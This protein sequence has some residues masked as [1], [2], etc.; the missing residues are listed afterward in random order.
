MP[1]IASDVVRTAPAT[2]AVMSGDSSKSDAD[3]PTVNV[4]A[5]WPAGTTTCVGACNRELL[6]CRDTMPPSAGAGW[7]SSREQT[8]APGLSGSGAHESE[9][10]MLVA[11]AW[12]LIGTESDVPPKEA[13]I[14]AV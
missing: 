12:R 3:T 8:K 9:L 11:G 13:V 1:T 7:L 5:R 6:A 14:V 4:T 10:I 2:L